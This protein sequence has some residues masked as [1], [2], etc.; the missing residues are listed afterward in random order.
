[1]LGG[2]GSGMTMRVRARAA[3]GR[4]RAMAATQGAPLGR[5]AKP[6]PGVRWLAAKWAAE[7]VRRAARAARVARK[8]GTAPERMRAVAAGSQRSR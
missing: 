4:L 1:M 7:R 3:R 5:V 6:G 8:A 2:V